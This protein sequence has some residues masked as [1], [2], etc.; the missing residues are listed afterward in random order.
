MG[1]NI[2]LIVV[3]LRLYGFTVF[4]P[5]MTILL[6]FFKH[7]YLFIIMIRYVAI[8]KQCYNDNDAIRYWVV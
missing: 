2:V 8:S 6:Y 7:A 3:S 4:S 1:P 5:I